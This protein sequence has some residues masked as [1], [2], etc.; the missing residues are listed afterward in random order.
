MQVNVTKMKEKRGIVNLIV[1]LIIS[2]LLI[3]NGVV[4]AQ[5]RLKFPEDIICGAER[6]DI[7]LDL[8]KNR[9]VGLVANQSSL[10]GGTHL[11]DSLLSSGIKVSLVFCPEHG[12]RGEGEAGEQI[13]DQK[14]PKTGI[15]VR[16]IYGDKKKPDP[17]DMKCLDVIVFDLQ[18][19]G[20][21]FYTYIS[22]LHYVMEAAAE[23]GKE[24][25]I[26]DRP[27]PNGFYVAGPVRESGFESFVG[28]HPVPV[29][30]GMTVGEYG[31]MINGEGWLAD[32]AKCCLRVIKCI[33][34]DHLCTYDLPVRPSP[35]LPNRESVILYPSLCFFEGTVVSLGRGT[36]FP[37]QVYGHPGMKGDF[38]FTPES[39]PGASLHPKL[40]GELCRGVD[41]RLNGPGRIIE[42]RQIILE[43]V[44]SAFRELGSSPDFF[45]PYFDT[46]M[47]NDSVRKD[48]T[49]GLPADSI[50]AKWQNGIN[51]FKKIRLKYL[52]YPD[53]EQ[54]IY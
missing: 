8:L 22:T 16:S 26:L 23:N 30:H 17:G 33:N 54:G 36:D 3:I 44:I 29:V 9:N 5:G 45:T 39:R 46:L 40:E 19:V 52:L 48:I 4:F 51:D 14:D 50:R 32:S 41:L 21:R 1:P 11:L 12:F 10:I 25:I 53:F 42:E 7:Y 13:I 43:W 37:F 18:D 20:A 6:T 27:N 24:V 34:Y 15:E 35:N 47:G 49:G 28:M 38:E 2:V 31:Q